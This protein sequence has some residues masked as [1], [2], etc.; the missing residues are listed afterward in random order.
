M[1]SSAAEEEVHSFDLN[2]LDIPLLIGAKL[3]PVRINV[4]PTGQLTLSSKSSLA[5]LESD[6]KG[7][8]W[9]YQAGLGIDLFKKLTIDARY[10]GNLSKL[11]ESVTIGGTAFTTD[12]RTSQVLIS[13]GIMF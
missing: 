4:G 1:D 9:G 12:K 6:V 11:G 2:R 3:G 10:E 13:V 5:A 7:M 8:V